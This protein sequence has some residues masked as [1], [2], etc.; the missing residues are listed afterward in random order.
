MSG[1][2]V[3]DYDY[4]HAKAPWWNAYLVPPIMELADD[5]GTGDRVL[6]IGC[7]NGYIAG[8]FAEK[9]CAVVG[10]D[11]SDSG[12][13][14]AREAH[15]A[16]RFEV[17]LA[18]PDL[19]ERLG[20]E[21][22]DLV[23]S[24][25]VAEHVYDADEWALACFHALKPGGQ[26]ILTTPYH[27]YLKNLAICVMNKWDHH[28]TSLRAGEHIKFW[29]RATMSE[30]LTRNGFRVEGFRGAGRMAYLWKSMVISARRP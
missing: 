13:A 5:L 25:E 26:L 4:A 7:G 21:P 17:D 12:I 14:Q 30:L 1:I 3:K 10:I 15:P 16:S 24:A 27:G 11:P 22:F 2:A 28:H 23:V 8:L 20:E 18:T 9:G 19:R 6:D 29:S